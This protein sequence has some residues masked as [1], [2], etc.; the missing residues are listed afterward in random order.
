MVPASTL[1]HLET[2]FAN[3]VNDPKANVIDLAEWM[4]IYMRHWENAEE[5]SE[6]A[7]REWER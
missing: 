4:E 7:V 3:F 2:A 6:G 1:R 5:R